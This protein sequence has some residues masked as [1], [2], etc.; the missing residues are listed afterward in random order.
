MSPL[1]LMMMIRES[2]DEEFYSYDQGREDPRG[3]SRTYLRQGTDTSE[4]RGR[5]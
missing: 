1:T 3:M 4:S 5:K 2:L